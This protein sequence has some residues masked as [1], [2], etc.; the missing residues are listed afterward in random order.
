[1]IR[2]KKILLHQ[3]L[4]E[5]IADAIRDD[6]IKGRL[7]AG[8]RVS[9]PELAAR[10]GISRTPVREAFRQLTAEGFL[11]LTPR[12]GARITYLTEKDVSEFY[13][14][15][16]VLEGYAAGIAA[17]KIKD[18]DLAR[19]EE[20][21]DQMQRF[22]ERGDLKHIVKV[23]NEFHDIFLEAAGNE[24]LYSTVRQ[25]ASRYQRFTI[26]LALTGKNPEAVSQH[27]KIIDAFRERDAK[28]AE[29]LVKANALLG[30]ELMIKEVLHSMQQ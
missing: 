20:L 29:E 9:E 27:R 17:A 23:H 24:Q 7:K 12:K 5:K 18:K 11:Q 15:K 6:I 30:K 3:T 1:M 19:M 13:E 16:S 28:R 10:Y 22:H 4:R 25:L 8:Q 21:N 14:L 2:V 26:L